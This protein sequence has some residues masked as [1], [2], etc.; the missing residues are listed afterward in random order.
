M[1]ESNGLVGMDLAD[2]LRK[3][4]NMDVSGGEEGIVSQLKEMAEISDDKKEGSFSFIC[5]GEGDEEVS[6][7]IFVEAFETKNGGALALTVKSHKE[8]VLPDEI[9]FKLG[10]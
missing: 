2:F 10:N 3:H 4:S 7:D 6:Y 1:A 8:D 9:L 5:P